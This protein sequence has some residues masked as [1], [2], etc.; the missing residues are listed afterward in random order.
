MNVSRPGEQAGHPVVRQR[1]GDEEQ[2]EA[3]DADDDAVDEAGEEPREQSTRAAPRTAGDSPSDR[4]RTVRRR[5]GCHVRS[6]PRGG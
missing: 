1:V 4:C 5:I 3:D 2:H 6:W